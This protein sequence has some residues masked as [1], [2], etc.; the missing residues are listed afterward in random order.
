MSFV[1]CV[2]NFSVAPNLKVEPLAVFAGVE[3]WP[4]VELVIGLA[5]PDDLGQV[6]R[7]EARLEP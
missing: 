6:A 5:D 3:V 4:E 7:L 2:G 1:A